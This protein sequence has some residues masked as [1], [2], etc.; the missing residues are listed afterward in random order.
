MVAPSTRRPY[1]KRSRC[2]QIRSERGLRS[3]APPYARRVSLPHSLQNPT[4]HMPGGVASANASEN[5]ANALRTHRPSMT[6]A[7]EDARDSRTEGD[8]S[9]RLTACGP[10]HRDVTRYVTAENCG[11]QG[12]R[13][14][15]T[16]SPNTDLH[17]F[18][19]VTRSLEPTLGLDSSQP[20]ARTHCCPNDARTHA[21]IC[22][23]FTSRPNLESY[24]RNRSSNNHTERPQQGKGDTLHVA[25]VWRNNE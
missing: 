21:E 20:R 11:R 25:M 18:N 16:E 13:I 7:V 19:D 9:R 12:L 1:S 15:T 17:D 5:D 24:H 6:N 22:L 14:S 23:F 2:S 3:A 4:G 8:A 10:C